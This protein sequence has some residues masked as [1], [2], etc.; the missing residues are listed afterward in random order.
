MGIAIGC[1]TIGAAIAIDYVQGPP[2]PPK[3]TIFSKII[4]NAFYQVNNLT[5][6]LDQIDQTILN[7]THNDMYNGKTAQIYQE[8]QEITNNLNNFY[9]E[10]K[11][12]KPLL[13]QD[14]KDAINYFLQNNSVEQFKSI[15]SFIKNIRIAK[16]ESL[17]SFYL[18]Q[19]V[20]NGL[21]G[22][23]LT[24]PPA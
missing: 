8:L 15:N 9:H 11:R 24:V 18:L 20:V 21:H 3:P 22:T 19:T 23:A 13:N 7:L 4:E 17:E 5:L 2:Q 16:N 10:I 6:K 1:I 12:I 14:D